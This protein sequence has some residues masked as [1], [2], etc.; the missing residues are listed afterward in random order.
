MTDVLGS[1]LA[2]VEA[3]V[4]SACRLDRK[5]G[6]SDWRNGRTVLWYEAGLLPGFLT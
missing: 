2:I 4:G 1:G 6:I 5:A 3:G